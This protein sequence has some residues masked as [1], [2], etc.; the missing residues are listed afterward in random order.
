[1]FGSAKE[2]LEQG[3]VERRKISSLPV[4]TLWVPQSKTI[5]FRCV[6]CFGARCRSAAHC[7]HLNVKPQ[8]YLSLGADLPLNQIFLQR[9]WKVWKIDPKSSSGNSL[10]LYLMLLTIPCAAW[11]EHSSV[12][13]EASSLSVLMQ[14]VCYLHFPRS[15]SHYLVFHLNVWVS[16]CVY[17]PLTV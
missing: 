16:H 7:E 2:C 15:P 14:P 6:L 4:K 12:S 9:T 11:T 1:M 8:Q 13:R 17:L 10:W 3:P 5:A